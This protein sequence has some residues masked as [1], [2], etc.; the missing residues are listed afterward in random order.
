LAKRLEILIKKIIWAKKDFLLCN[1]CLQIKEV[2]L[3]S[4]FAVENSKQ[5][6]AARYCF[7]WARTLLKIFIPFILNEHLDYSFIQ[8]FFNIRRKFTKSH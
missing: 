5:Y 8:E 4:I 2:L 7:N 3:Q 1:I 6:E